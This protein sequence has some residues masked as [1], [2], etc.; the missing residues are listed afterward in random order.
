MGQLQLF[1]GYYR[2]DDCGRTTDRVRR[3]RRFRLCD[4]C[5]GRVVPEMQTITMSMMGRP[6]HEANAR[7]WAWYE[8]MERRRP[9]RYSPP[10]KSPVVVAR[11][12]DQFYPLC[13]CGGRR[14]E[15]SST[16][17]RRGLFGGPF[18]PECPTCRAK[19]EIEGHVRAGSWL[20][21]DWDDEEWLDLLYQVMP[22]AFELGVLPDYWYE[23]Q[24]GAAGTGRME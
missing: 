23:L 22:E 5:Y 14:Q 19:R 15:M 7:Y 13:A 21:P 8:E 11:P 1:A 2:C 6:A 3:T 12:T 18:L 9:S 4:A 20:H 24:R 17:G 10:V 16:R